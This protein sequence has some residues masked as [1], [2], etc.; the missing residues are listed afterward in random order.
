MMTITSTRSNKSADARRDFD[1]FDVDEELRRFRLARFHE[2]RHVAADLLLV[3]GAMRVTDLRSALSEWADFDLAEFALARC[4]GIIDPV[5]SWSPSYKY[6]FWSN[7]PVGNG[8]ADILDRLV[9]MGA[10]ET[11]DDQ[12][13]RWN[14]SFDRDRTAGKL[15]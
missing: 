11:N 14:Q 2:Q 9:A 13:Y 15:P 3:E 12:Q 5:V 7:N 6:L 1:G 10:L 4:L 8:L